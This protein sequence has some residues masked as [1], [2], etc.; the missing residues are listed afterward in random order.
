MAKKI[1][2]LTG[3]AILALSCTV[4]RDTAPEGAEAK[5]E[6]NQSVVLSEALSPPPGPP[7]AQAVAKLSA[8]GYVRADAEMD[9]AFNTDSFNTEA[10]DHLDENAFLAVAGNPLSTFSIDVDTASYANLRRFLMQG[11]LPPG[12]AVRIEELV[13]YFS[14]DYPPPAGDAPFSADVE[15]AAAPWNPRHRLARIGLKGEVIADGDRPAGNLVFLLDV[16]GSMQSANKLPLVKTAMRMLT[17]RL[18]GDDRVSI[19]VYAGAAGLVLPSTAADDRQTILSAIERLEAGGSTAGGA[20]I[21]LAYATAREGFIS[22]GVN[23][24]ILCSDGD[25]N[26]GVTNQSDLVELIEREAADGIFLTVLGFGMGNYKDSTLEKL[27][28]HGNGNYGYIDSKLEA[29]KMLVE[30]IGGTLITIAKDVKIQVEFNP[31][32]VSAYRLIGY[33]NRMLRAEEFNDDT[34]DAGEIGAGHT[35][36]A[37]YELVPAGQEIDLPGV[38]PLKYQRP[39]AGSHAA[40]SNELFTLKLRY[41]EPD[42][43]TSRLLE[44]PVPDRGGSLAG[45]SDD[46]KFAASVAAFGMILRG[47]EHA[48]GF[49][50]TDAAALAEQGRGDDAAGYRAEFIDLV[51]RARTIQGAVAEIH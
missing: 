48:D 43:R 35:V 47:S 12:G 28:D 3:I 17:E 34:K 19:V 38:D 31:R 4:Q 20:G 24:V 6:A 30:Q 23:R 37:L 41:K 36:T 27:A 39:A 21:K 10:Y 44:Y 29:R 33:E 22:G 14:Y 42:G 11:Q 8:M 49:S 7:R 50:L 2:T 15:I 51:A 5:D 13:N 26:V 45:A 9:R 18:D 32:L 16:S 46:F 1:L 40:D 25:F